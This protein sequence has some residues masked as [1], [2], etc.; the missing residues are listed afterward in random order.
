MSSFPD[1]TILLQRSC[2]K[3]ED[4]QWLRFADPVRRIT[5]TELSEVHSALIDVQEAT[6]QGYYAAGFVTYE[7]SAAFDKALTTHEPGS[8]PLLWF[9]IYDEPDVLCDLPIGND[10]L[11]KVGDWHLPISEEEYSAVI[12]Q[13]RDYI[14]AGDTYQVNYTMRLSAPF[15]GEPFSLFRI[16]SSAQQASHCAYIQRPGY[17]IC[18]ASPELFFKRQGYRLSSRP[19]K[20]TE[21]R[22]CT[23][24]EDRKRIARLR[25]SEKDRAENVMIVDMIRNDMGRIASPGT[26]QVSS[27]Y[28]VERYPTVLQMTSTVDCETKASFPDIMK[29]LFPC[30][31]ITGAPKVHTMKII[32][33]LE[34]G[35]RGVYTGAIGYVGPDACAEFNVG[36]RT[37][38]IDRLEGQAEYGVGGGIIWDSDSIAEYKECNTKAAVLTTRRPE[39]DLLETILWTPMDGWFLLDRHLARL[40]DS[41][42]YF[43]FKLDTYE[44]R[45]Q[46]DQLVPS[47]DGKRWRVRL[48]LSQNG[49]MR[50]DQS[51][52]DDVVDDNE[53]QL[54]MAKHAV[55]SN[56]PFL[57]HK[58][59]HRS[60][61]QRA[62]DG[63]AD[64][65][66]VIL[67]NEKGEIT[68]ATI[69]NLVIEQGGEKLTPPVSSG[70]LAGTFRAGLLESGQIRE[71]VLT[72]QDLK[73][74]DCIYLVN[75]V[76]RWIRAELV[77]HRI[78]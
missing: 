30:A 17:C 63:A 44:I 32:T 61:Y 50:T 70:L 58:T 35:P 15:S 48:L 21:R 18:S 67:F 10:V 76:R 55:N 65:D 8:L 42:D 9:G 52:L 12:E 28:D 69:A 33:E 11:F 64:C 34:S 19:M 68:E 2:G 4:S 75:S 59:T 41:A 25:G 53:Q 29:A 7:A 24:K 54:C 47:F 49:R 71:K 13:I 66:D 72:I 38:V 73:T 26:V 51:K 46:L 27:L 62:R 40:A 57:Y 74:A 1:D 23:T 60:V 37:V 14:Y 22:G 6:E 36:I 77:D 16:L 56:D 78:G 5:A 31:S 20:G 43:K 3:Q 45:T 39:F